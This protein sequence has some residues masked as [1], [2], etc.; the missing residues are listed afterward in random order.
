[1]RSLC[2]I[3]DHIPLGPGRPD[4]PGLPTGPGLP[5]S[6]LTPSNPAGPWNPRSP[7]SPSIPGKPG[8]P[9]SPFSPLTLIVGPGGPRSPFSPGGPVTPGSPSGP[10]N[11]FQ[12]QPRATVNMYIHQTTIIR[13][14]TYMKWIK[15]IYKI[16]YLAVHDLLWRRPSQ[17]FQV[18]PCRRRGRGIQ[19]VLANRC[20]QVH[21]VSHPIQVCQV[22]QMVQEDPEE[23]QLTTNNDDFHKYRSE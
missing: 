12:I 22:H 10:V 19:E 17:V 2:S 6:P 13:R 5:L 21:Q 14:L 18:I 11:R 20:H 9:G 7:F 3:I 4:G 16:A 1:M 23:E 15:N 8:F